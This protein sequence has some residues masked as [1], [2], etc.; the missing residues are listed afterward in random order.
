MASSP[1]SK[2]EPAI[3]GGLLALAGAVIASLIGAAALILTQPK[4]PDLFARIA[5]ELVY[6]IEVYVGDEYRG[7]VQP[8]GSRR[9]AVMQPSKVWAR[10]DAPGEPVRAS[11]F[12]VVAGN[13]LTFHNVIGDSTIFSPRVTNEHD[14]GCTVSVNGD[15]GEDA[16]G[17]M[18][19][20]AGAAANL[21]YFFLTDTATVTFVCT[22]GRSGWWGRQRGTS[23]GGLATLIEDGTGLMR[24]RISAQSP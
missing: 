13:N 11:W 16:T 2:R 15:R 18:D 23:T 20:R 6:P 14:T 3:T 10:V 22:D 19:I 21:G 4:E 5:N 24:L 8:D 1:T 9:V 7:S 12:D 17:R